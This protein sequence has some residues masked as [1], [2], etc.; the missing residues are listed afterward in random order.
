MNATVIA[1]LEAALVELKA[2]KAEVLETAHKIMDNN[3]TIGANKY[4]NGAQE[5]LSANVKMRSQIKNLEAV[6]ATF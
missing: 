5:L 2:Q 4:A 1:N 3:A 6:L